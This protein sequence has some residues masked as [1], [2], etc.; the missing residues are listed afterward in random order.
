MLQETALRF[1]LEEGFAKP[2]IVCNEEHRFIIAAQ[3]QAMGVFPQAVILEPMGRNTAPAAAVAA[4]ML[5]EQSPDALMLMLP[6]DHVIADPDGFRAAIRTGAR[7]AASGR[8]VTFGIPSA[9]PETGYGYIRKGAASKDAPGTFA[10]SAFV[11]K[12]D[13]RTAEGYLASGDYY[14]NAGIFLFSPAAYLDELSAYAPEIVRYARE[15]LKKARRDLDFLRLD[16]D[17][18]GKCPSISIDYAVMERT[19]LATVVP[20][21]I[22]WSD[23]GSWSAVADLGSKDELGN[24]VSGDVLLEDS[25]NNFVRSESRLVTALGVENLVIVETTDAV[26]VATRDR[27]QDV[28]RVVERLIASK[29]T[30]ATQHAR[31]YRP[32]GFFESLHNAPGTQVKLIGVNPGAALS[33]QYHHKRA[34]HWVVVSGE[35]WVTRG[36][37]SFALKE[38]ES[39][40]IPIGMKHRLE[41]RRQ[42]PL[43]IIEVQVGSYLGE[44]DIVRL[45]DIYRRTSES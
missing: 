5:M 10:V 44:D 13:R 39:V 32:W 19:K 18:F 15:A 6:S 20:A 14:W 1:P 33:L 21:D 36:E 16:R 37:D 4:Q 17:A 31:V 22:G 42:D 41:N 12:P 2:V 3:L 28:K 38:N 43:R 27:D 11:E 23:L 35:A 30:E 25:R 45:E 40:Y 8:L 34:E 26:L 29:R 24:V 7:A 9:R